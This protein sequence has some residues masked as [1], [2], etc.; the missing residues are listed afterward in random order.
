MTNSQPP[1]EVDSTFNLQRT[2]VGDEK[3]EIVTALVVET[4]L[5]LILTQDA[6][7]VN[8]PNYLYVPE[9]ASLQIFGDEITVSGKLG[10]PGRNVVI[11]ARALLGQSD[12]TN[13]P[14]ISVDGA[15]LPE[16]IAKPKPLIQGA[17]VPGQVAKGKVK[18]GAK[19]DQGVSNRADP[20]GFEWE[21]RSPGQPGWSGPDHP[22]EMNGEPGNPGA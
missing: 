2:V 1:Y 16:E 19:G 15:P 22:N 7:K 17:E 4:S 5:P 13:P 20:M 8:Q 3:N 11:F 14:T 21:T 12:G 10:F 9:S 18:V 6:A